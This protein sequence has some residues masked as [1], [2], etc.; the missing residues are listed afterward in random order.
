MAITSSH[1]S[2]FRQCELPTPN[3]Y[4]MFLEN[5]PF[6]EPKTLLTIFSIFCTCAVYTGRGTCGIASQCR[7]S[8]VRLLYAQDQGKRI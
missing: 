3:T 8:P 4:H 1:K 6:R 5:K 2:Q 7:L